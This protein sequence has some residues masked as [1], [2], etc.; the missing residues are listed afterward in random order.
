MRNEEEDDR[1]EE[2]AAAAAAGVAVEAV[3]EQVTAAWRALRRARDWLQAAA[4]AECVWAPEVLGDEEW[5]W[6]RAAGAEGEERGASEAW[7]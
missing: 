2:E 5:P 3:A 6:R 4:A 1:T 7:A